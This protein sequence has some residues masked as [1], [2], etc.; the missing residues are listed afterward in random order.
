MDKIDK[1]F[2]LYFFSI[3]IVIV[4]IIFV[5][6]KYELDLVD[7]ECF[8]DIAKQHCGEKLDGEFYKFYQPNLAPSGFYCLSGREIT[9]SGNSLRFSQEETEKCIERRGLN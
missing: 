6:L 7:Q 9:P 1:I 8:E 5:I 2:F 4:L 3:L